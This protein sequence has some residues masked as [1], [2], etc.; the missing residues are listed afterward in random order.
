MTKA[1]SLERLNEIKTDYENRR[2]SRSGKERLW[3]VIGELLAIIEAPAGG[4]T[5]LARH[6]LIVMEPKNP[7][8]ARAVPE[9]PMMAHARMAESLNAAPV[10]A[11]ASVELTPQQRAAKFAADQ[12]ARD[13]ALTP[14]ERE[15]LL[16]A[17]AE[18]DALQQQKF[19][20]WKGQFDPDAP[21]VP[22]RA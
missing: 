11:V 13:A 7:D 20:A 10:P 6:P 14:A 5:V 12:R 19:Q 21:Y 1:P 4:D 9:G 18:A 17:E 16:A 2:R 3:A 22:P 8:A 15:S